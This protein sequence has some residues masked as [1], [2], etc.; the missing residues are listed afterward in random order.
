MLQETTLVTVTTLTG[1][2]LDVHILQGSTVFHLK[3]AISDKWGLP[4]SCQ[5]IISTGSVDELQDDDKVTQPH[6]QMLVSLLGVCHLLSSGST[7]QRCAAFDD[8]GKL[9]TLGMKVVDSTAISD[10]A[11]T[12]AIACLGDRTG[13]LTV[14]S[15]GL[16]ALVELAGE[17]DSRREFAAEIEAWPRRQRPVHAAVGCRKAGLQALGRFAERG[18]Q[19]AISAVRGRLDDR[20]PGIRV[21]ALQALASLAERR[22]QD[23]IAAVTARLRD[24]ASE[25]QRAA[26]Q[27]LTQIAEKGDQE[28]IAAA[29]ALLETEDRNLL[30]DTV[31]ALA[32]LA[33]RGDRQAIA[34]VS[35]KLNC[36]DLAVQGAV[37]KALTQLAERGDQHVI[38]TMSSLLVHKDW[39]IRRAALR[40][41][42]Q[43]ARQGDQQT[44]TAVIA[45][46]EDTNWIVRQGAVQ[47]LSELGVAG[48]N[49]VISA[50]SARLDDEVRV[51]NAVVEALA[52]LGTE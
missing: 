14:M 38:T 29:S 19:R 2:S 16:H 36:K 46:L 51:R 30:L 25:V 39:A 28:V 1:A 9:A 4:Q 31:E 17:G 6:Y 33:E 22:S 48:D 37:V 23:A 52:R 7:S 5:K 20:D 32:Q 50:L 34:T 42:A 15:A 3:S 47:A 41:L 49:V 27:A 35:S 26:V 40:A 11:I 18:D 12:V 43:L 24:R 13:S 45:C 8:V 21:A 10:A 44:I